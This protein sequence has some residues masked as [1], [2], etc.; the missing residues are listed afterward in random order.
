[1]TSIVLGSWAPHPPPRRA[2]ISG[3]VAGVAQNTS[4][5]GLVAVRRGH[6]S[7]WGRV[8]SGVVQCSQPSA[9]IVMKYVAS[10]HEVCHSPSLNPPAS[11]SS[12][13]TWV[14]SPFALHRTSPAYRQRSSVALPPRRAFR[15][16][17]NVSVTD[18]RKGPAVQPASALGGPI[19]E[20]KNGQV[21]GQSNG[22][23]VDTIAA[24]TAVTAADDT[25]S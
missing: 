1:M 9:P 15:L 5:R 6:L 13:F 25:V 12:S 11:R 20:K 10:D 14:A 23:E 18:H 2:R 22:D 4:L 7:R 24:A 8:T 17:T 19:A 21:T 3:P 16:R